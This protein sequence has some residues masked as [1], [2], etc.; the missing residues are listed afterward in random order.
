[1]LKIFSMS[2]DQLAVLPSLKP[3][4]KDPQNKL[5]IVAS[6]TF[7]GDKVQYAGLIHILC[8][9]IGMEGA[10]REPGDIRIL[11][12]PLLFLFLFS[13]FFLW[14]F[15]CRTRLRRF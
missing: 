1:M 5:S 12:S 10:Q 6:F 13:N 8:R 2:N 4:I 15:R 3:F 14:V 7:S 9:H 11:I